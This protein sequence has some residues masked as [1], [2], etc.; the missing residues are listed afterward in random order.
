MEIKVD[1]EKLNKEKDLFI[2][3]QKQIMSDY[4]ADTGSSLFREDAMAAALVCLM[5][6]AYKIK[7]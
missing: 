2:Q 7:K 4:T 5:I 1:Y 6:K 3:V